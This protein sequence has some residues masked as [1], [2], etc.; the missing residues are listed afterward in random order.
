[1]EIKFFIKYLNL[2]AA[3]LIIAVLN[4]GCGNSTGQFGKVVKYSQNESVK[5]PDFDIVF[6]G[7]SDKTSA[8]DNGNSF[9]FH[10]Y[11][12]KITSPA[13]SK[14]VQWSQGTGLI[15]PVSFELG[16]KM[17]SIELKHS[18]LFS[19]ELADDEMIVTKLEKNN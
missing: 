7:E 4:A 15:A 5:Y 18:Q 9:K 8:F 12:F 3:I 1:M 14:I 10:Y 19:K 11:D 2:L 6:T 13:E 17:Y 16:S